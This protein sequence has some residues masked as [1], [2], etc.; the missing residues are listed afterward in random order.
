MSRLLTAVSVLLLV[1]VAICAVQAAPLVLADKGVSGYRIVLG[2]QASPSERH[3]AAELQRFLR[4]ISGAEL[5]IVGDDEPVTAHEVMVGRSAH[6]QALGV[7][8]DWGKL[9]DEGFVLRTLGPHLVIAGGRLRG[10]MYGVYTFLEDVLGCRW[11]SSD[12]SRIPKLDRIVV[13]ALDRT[14]VPALEYRE[15]FFTD[16][17]D[18]DW[19]ARNKANGDHS[20][21][22]AEQGGKNAYV[23][24]VHTFASLVPSGQYFATHPE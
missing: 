20:G 17:F 24:F 22:T 13:P 11:Y 10:T 21:L 6:F 12:A 2:A 15:P 4:E 23:G 19:S 14:V 5:P 7:R 9:G 1:G 3:A 16:A 8:F 18:G